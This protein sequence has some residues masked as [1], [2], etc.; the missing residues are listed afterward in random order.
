MKKR[1]VLLIW[2][3]SFYKMTYLCKRNKT[4]LQMN[5][6]NQPVVLVVD[7]ITTNITLIKAL[8]RGKN[9]EVLVAQSGTQALEIAQQQHPDLILLDIMM[10]V[11]DGYEVLARLRSDEKTKDIRVVILSALANESDIKNAMDLG[12]DAYLTKPVIARKLYETLEKY[13]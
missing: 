7:D 8:L 11:M 1:Y 9:Y 4:L 5:S 6:K 10:P 2:E 13:I 3:R 12:A